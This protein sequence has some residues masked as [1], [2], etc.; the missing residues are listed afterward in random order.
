MKL[1]VITLVAVVVLA[2]SACSKSEDSRF[3]DE[4]SEW[5][6]KAEINYWGLPHAGRAGI[7]SNIDSNGYESLIKELEAIRPVPTEHEREYFYLVRSHWMLF[8][9]RDF[10]AMFHATGRWSDNDIAT[11]LAQYVNYDVVNHY[12]RRVEQAAEENLAYA[13]KYWNDILGF[14]MK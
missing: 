11:E 10:T 13:Q 14:P 2:A 9:A 7:N 3:L 1:I 12:K 4:M 8:W 5:F 6:G